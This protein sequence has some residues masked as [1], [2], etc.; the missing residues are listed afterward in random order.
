MRQNKQWFNPT[1]TNALVA[2]V[3]FGKGLSKCRPPSSVAPGHPGQTM[4]TGGPTLQQVT[5]AGAP[6]HQTGI[7]ASVGQQQPGQPGRKYVSNTLIP[8]YTYTVSNTSLF[9]S[10]RENAKQHKDKYQV[11]LSFNASLQQITTKTEECSAW[12]SIKQSN[13]LLGSVWC[14]CVWMYVGFFL[15]NTPLFFLLKSYVNLYLFSLFIWLGI[16]S[17]SHCISLA[18]LNLPLGSKLLHLFDTT[19]EVT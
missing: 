11:G 18:V 4:M 7:G 14:V 6:G 16:K 9:W 1:D 5:I 8:T 19:V 13:I 3:G 2:A 10:L 17:F 12:A 15:L